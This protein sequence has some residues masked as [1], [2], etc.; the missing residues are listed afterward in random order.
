M[1]S[2]SSLASK[3]FLK[4]GALLFYANFFA[5]FLGSSAPA[6]SGEPIT[7][8]VI[9]PY[10]FNPSSIEKKTEALL[11]K[12]KP[13]H[14]DGLSWRTSKA[15]VNFDE[16]SP[17]TFRFSTSI[18][19]RYAPK[20]KNLIING[21]PIARSEHGDFALTLPV[22]SEAQEYQLYAVD[23]YG[24]AEEES[25]ILEVKNWK[26]ARKQL[27]GAQDEKPPNLNPSSI[28]FFIGG[29]M[30][31]YQE[32]VTGPF[33]ENGVSAKLLFERALS[34][35]QRYN[36][37]LGSFFTALPLS[38]THPD[39]ST[40]TFFGI[41]GLVSYQTRWLKSPWSLSF[42]GGIFFVTSSASDSSFGF[43][44]VM[45]PQLFPTLSRKFSSKSSAAIYF[46]YSPTGTKLSANLA[47]HEIAGGISWT[48]TIFES[49][50]LIFS[51]DMNK[52]SI[53]IDDI[54]IE[55]SS[56]NLS[57]GFGF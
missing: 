32:P 9:L 23:D 41:N 37:Q 3:I 8:R 10:Q 26:R 52:M 55:W 33:S 31:R 39:Q 13:S 16:P 30:Y 15:P 35:D 47:N 1:R 43:Q 36:F 21:M 27:M 57:V 51:F 14:I 12:I 5:V 28:Y 20:D 11:K 56:Y 34:S 19:G 40:L 7:A 54:P 25:I 53:K 44:N 4:L 24:K 17:G 42:S 29:S 46:K 49:T 18:Q 45:G 38:S 48:R 2:D 50:P 6:F 22:G